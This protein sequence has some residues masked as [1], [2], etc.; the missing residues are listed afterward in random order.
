MTGWK[1]YTGIVKLLLLMVVVPLAVCLL[2]FRRSVALW[3]ESRENGEMLIS[4]RSDTTSVR[5]LE[6]TPIS[7]VNANILKNGE[8]LNRLNPVMDSLRITAERYTPYLITREQGMEIYV[9]EI[10]LNGGYIS[11]TRLLAE[12]EGLSS[13][14]QVVSAEYKTTENLQTRKRSLKLTLVLQQITQTDK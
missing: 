4:A 11:L 10:V 6:V 13:A 8:L 9:G 2:G 14:G 7:L 12:T 1:N 3:Q 5:S